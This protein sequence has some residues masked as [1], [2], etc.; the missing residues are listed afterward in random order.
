[1]K[2]LIAAI[3]LL[4]VC[5]SLF[6]ACGFL[7]KDKSPDLEDIYYDYCSPTWAKLGSDGTYLEIDTN[8]YDI[9]DTGIAYMDAYYAIENVNRALGLPDSLFKEMGRTSGIDGKQTEVFE[10]QGVTVSWKY[11]PDNGC[12]VI[13]KVEKKS[14]PI[15]DLLDSFGF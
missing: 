15:E 2:K 13:Y 9:D 4:L 1:M 14:S 10:E 11:H 3:A 8:P 7:P 12:E 6:C 5:T